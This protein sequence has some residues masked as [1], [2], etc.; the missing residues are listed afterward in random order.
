MKKL[1]LLATTCLFLGGCIS[2]DSYKP[3]TLYTETATYSKDTL[4]QEVG[5]SWDISDN[6]SFD[7]FVAPTIATSSEEDSYFGG[8]FRLTFELD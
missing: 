2:G 4:Y 3:T 8:G 1:L 7:L 5:M 6:A